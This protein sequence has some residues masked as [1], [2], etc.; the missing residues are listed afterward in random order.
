MK[1]RLLKNKT[2]INEYNK[3]FRIIKRDKL[4]KNINNSKNRI[5]YS[6]K[7]NRLNIH[8]NYLSQNKKI[9]NNY[10]INKNNQ[11]PN[12]KN[13]YFIKLF[14]EEKNNKINEQ[15]KKLLLKTS[16]DINKNIDDYLYNSLFYSLNKNVQNNSFKN[17]SK[18]KNNYSLSLRGDFIKNNN[19]IIINPYGNKYSLNKKNKYKIYTNTQFNKNNRY[20]LSSEKNNI[21]SNYCDASTNTNA[22]FIKFNKK[23]INN[24]INNKNNYVN[25]NNHY[26]NDYYRNK[27]NISKTIKRP[28]MI[29]YLYSE[30]KKLYYGFD[31]L[32]GKDR[33]KKPFFIVHK[34]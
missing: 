4:Y 27:I 31:K 21:T 1:K 22:D 17:S 23:Y 26:N 13:V 7:H 6:A 8:D 29:D 9:N 10:S 28:L 16:R 2:E 14:N 19:K 15:S 18:N 11:I 34:Y 3:T 32:K 25:F 24:N 30:H 20:I 12:I 5:T 33:N